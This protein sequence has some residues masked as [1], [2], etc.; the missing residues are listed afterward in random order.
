MQVR[1]QAPKPEVPQGYSSPP[2]SRGW[3]PLK[4]ETAIVLVHVSKGAFNCDA[5]ATSVSGESGGNN[6]ASN[7]HF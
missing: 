2:A 3:T 4:L 1:N 5:E 7:V 6:Y